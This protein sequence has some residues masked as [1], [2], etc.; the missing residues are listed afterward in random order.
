MQQ[1][2]ETKNWSV[3]EFR[4]W[5]E[6]GELI[7]QPKFQRRDV[8]SDKARSYLLDTI[9]RGK[10][11]PKIYLRVEVNPRS[12]RTVRE[13]V[14]GQQRLRSVLDFLKNGFKI[15]KTH[16]EDHG[17]KY[18]SDID[19][20]V[21][22]NI[23]AYTFAV[24]VLAD[25][26]DKDIYDVFARLNTYSVTL[27]YQELRHAKYFGEFKTTAYKLSNEFMTFWQENHIFNDKQILRMNEAEF[28][29]EL[30]IAA[31]VGIRAKEKRLIDSFYLKWDN[32]FPRGAAQEKRFRQTIDTIG[33]ITGD[34]LPESK[35]RTTALLYPLCCAVY[36][37]RYGLP[38]FDEERVAIKTSDYQRLGN[39]LVKIDDI[40][41]KLEDAEEDAEFEEGVSQGIIEVDESEDEEIGE[42]PED[43]DPLTPQERKFYNAFAEH[44]V[45]AKN[46]KTLTEY[47]Y[48]VMAKSLRR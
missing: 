6:A 12:K 45:H 23:L 37:F 46:R 41:A 35:F 20:D 9:I 2:F 30:L 15:S 24:D 26:V 38:E 11:I 43:F 29:S 25:M 31:S 1:R 14:D 7:L 8:W 22:D 40:F 33:G 28:V 5:E 4:D 48:K 36:H 39:A 10:P 34:R 13:V 42:R 21:Q 18:F 44:W 16:N 47:I 19:E 3:E 17:G 27:N 32:D